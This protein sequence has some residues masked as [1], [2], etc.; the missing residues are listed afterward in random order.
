MPYDS[1]YLRG[2]MA[3]G[4]AA[5]SNDGGI[6]IRVGKGKE[7]ICLSIRPQSIAWLTIH[8]SSRRTV[9]PTTSTLRR[10]VR[11]RIRTP[12]LPYAEAH[13]ECVAE[14]Q[15]LRPPVPTLEQTK[16]AKLSEINAA[17]DGAIATLHGDLSRP[18]DQHVRQAGIEGRA[19]AADLRL[20]RRFFRR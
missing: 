3:G 9:C 4:A 10:R 16:A 20:Q 14:E 5:P 1:H 12:C 13:P 19:Y 8:T 17:A 11:G 7:E 6:A 2:V 18:V 15:P